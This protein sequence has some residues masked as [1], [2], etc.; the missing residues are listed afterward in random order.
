MTQ[1]LELLTSRVSEGRRILVY[2]AGHGLP[3]KQP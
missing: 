1:Y 2:G 3:A